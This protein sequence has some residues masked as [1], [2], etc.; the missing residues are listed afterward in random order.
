MYL[1]SYVPVNITNSHVQLVQPNQSA[2]VQ[3]MSPQPNQLTGPPDA[4]A[5]MHDHRR[6]KVR[7]RGIHVVNHLRVEAERPQ[8]VPVVRAHGE[9]EVE[10]GLRR[11]WNAVVG[12]GGEVK[13]ENFSR[14]LKAEGYKCEK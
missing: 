4:S 3:Q 1:L 12:P 13:M 8:T 14:L 11:V 5:A 7:R 6:R 10:E 2:S 9:Q